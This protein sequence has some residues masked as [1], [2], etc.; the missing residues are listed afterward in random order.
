MSIYN[1]GIIIK[2]DMD[3]YC[4]NKEVYLDRWYFWIMSA[5]RKRRYQHHHIPECTY[6]GY[7]YECHQSYLGSLS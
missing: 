6:E 2:E 4:R 5:R 7:H 3:E 1:Y